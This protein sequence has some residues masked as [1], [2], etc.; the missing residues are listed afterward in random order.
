MSE[1]DIIAE[2]TA[3][4]QADDR[5]Q[6]DENRSPF[7]EN[8]RERTKELGERLWEIGKL[9]LMQK[10][11]SQMPKYDQHELDCCWDGVG[12]WLW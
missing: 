7:L 5:H 11:L 9:P 6:D 12:D 3:M 8:N 1:Q 10:A 2:L 4:T